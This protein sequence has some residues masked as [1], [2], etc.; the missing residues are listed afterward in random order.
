[1]GAWKVE[2]GGKPNIKTTLVI[3]TSSFPGLSISL[4][5]SLLLGKQ[6]FMV[7]PGEMVQRYPY[8][9]FRPWSPHRFNCPLEESFIES[10][11]QTLCLLKV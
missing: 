6:H 5:P 4:S 10:P 9:C 8:K 3:P 2:G 11:A 7:R 1:M